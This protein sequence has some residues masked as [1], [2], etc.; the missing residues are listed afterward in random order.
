[1]DTRQR[2]PARSMSHTPAPVV[3]SGGLDPLPVR[4]RTMHDPYDQPPDVFLEV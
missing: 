3:V 2:R 4:C 1:M